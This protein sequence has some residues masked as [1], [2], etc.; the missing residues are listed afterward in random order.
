MSAQLE[1]PLKRGERGPY[2]ERLDV[3]APP[4][5]VTLVTVPQLNELAQRFR[6]VFDMTTRLTN[7]YANARQ[8]GPPR[9]VEET[10]LGAPDVPKLIPPSGWREVVLRRRPRG[11]GRVDPPPAPS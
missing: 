2:Q 11:Q 9:P 1:K 8:F 10:M 7:D 6:W 5:G 3:E 4:L